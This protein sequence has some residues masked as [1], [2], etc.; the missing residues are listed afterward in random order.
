[1]LKRKIIRPS[2]SPWASPVVVVDKKGGTKRFC[3][4]YR[5][6]NA[7]T[8][9]DQFPLPRIDELLE[10]FRSKRWFTTLDLSSG[11]WQVVLDEESKKK[12]AFISHRGLHE[13]NV[14]P[15]GLCNAPSTF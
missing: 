2:K 8:K 3:V 13:F 15:F 11:F 5:G 9:K 1:M 14:M 10:T 7:L 4:D 12:T 6:L